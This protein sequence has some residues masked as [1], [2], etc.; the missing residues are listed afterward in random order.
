MDDRRCACCRTRF[1]PKHNPNQRYCGASLCQK[2]RRSRYQQKKLKEDSVYNETH[3]SSQEKW[4]AMHPYYWRTYRL[5]HQ[6][7]VDKNRL[8]Q[9]MRD[10]R[11]RD[12]AMRL[13]AEKVGNTVETAEKSGYKN[14]LVNMYVSVPK[15]NYFSCN[16]SINLG[17]ENGL[18]I[19]T[20]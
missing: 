8:L 3:Q 1:R 10:Q 11:R 16:Y 17:K 19:C 15:I 12:K 18:Q 5:T 6:N 14:V 20:L 9:G 13:R 4:R 7:Y 2:K